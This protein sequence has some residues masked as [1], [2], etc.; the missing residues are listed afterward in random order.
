M[1]KKLDSRKLFLI[2]SVIKEFLNRDQENYQ[3]ANVHFPVAGVAAEV[4]APNCSS[5][6]PARDSLS[7]QLVTYMVLN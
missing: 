1:L 6:H 4:T 7:H 3:F 2:C 5:Q